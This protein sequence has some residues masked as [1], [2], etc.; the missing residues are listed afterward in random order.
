MAAAFLGLHQFTTRY[1]QLSG[2][3]GTP[4]SDRLTRGFNAMLELYNSVDQMACAQSMQADAASGK[5]KNLQQVLRPILRDIA[6]SILVCYFATGADG[7]S[8]EGH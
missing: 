7:G 4:T 6:Q 1:N 2:L 3:G 8:C 5:K